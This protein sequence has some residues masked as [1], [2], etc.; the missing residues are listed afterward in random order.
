MGKLDWNFEV[1]GSLLTRT[2]VVLET[3][4]YLPV[5]HMTQQLAPGSFIERINLFVLWGRDY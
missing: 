3:L 2:V 1:F 5:Y 4:V